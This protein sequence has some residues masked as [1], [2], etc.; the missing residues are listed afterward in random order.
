MLN[1]ASEWIGVGSSS[2]GSVNA[3]ISNDGTLNYSA[4]SFLGSLVNGHAGTLNLTGV[5]QA[6]GAVTNQGVVTL[7]NGGGLGGSTLDNQNTIT[8]AGG[9]LTGGT[10]NNNGSIS[11]YG[12]FSGDSAL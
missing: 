11:G 12:S 4:G 9:T 7:N 5:L 3:A 1:V 8:L 2:R 10:I 6:S